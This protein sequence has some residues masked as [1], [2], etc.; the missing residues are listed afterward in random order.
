MF[1]Q[2]ISK[3]TDYRSHEWTGSGTGRSSL[4]MYALLKWTRWEMHYNFV[5]LRKSMDFLV[6]KIRKSRDPG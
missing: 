3:T 2:K 4:H 1:N 6:G 5:I